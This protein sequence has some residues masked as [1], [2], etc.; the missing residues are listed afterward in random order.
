[1][2][3]KLNLQYFGHL[4]QKFDSLEKTLMLGGIE[5]S[6]RRGWQRM[7]WLDRI[8]DYSM[9]MSLSELQELVMDREAWHAAIIGVVKSQTWL[10]DWPE[11]NWGKPEL[12]LMNFGG[13]MWTHLRV[14]N[15]RETK[16]KQGPHT[17]VSFTSRNSN[18][19][20]RGCF[21]HLHT[22]PWYY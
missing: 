20:T 2:M 21:N 4:M 22:S 16:S 3:L 9:D 6:R 13:S 18:H 19:R 10:R 1:M 8:T 14:K 17:P 11:L 5:G 12:W 7:R 15:S